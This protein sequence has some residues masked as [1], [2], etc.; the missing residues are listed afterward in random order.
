MKI[1]YFLWHS[2]IISHVLWIGYYMSS[3]VIQY[4]WSLFRVKQETMVINLYCTATDLWP[5]FLVSLE[6]MVIN[7]IL[8]CYEC[9]NQLVSWPE[10]MKFWTL[11]WLLYPI[12]MKSHYIL[13]NKY[14]KLKIINYWILKKYI[15]CFRCYTI[16]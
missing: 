1:V 4:L 9:H 6:T 13:L 12:Y 3:S 5:L 2:V 14:Y 11:N 8:H 16:K 7:A 15:L 10:R